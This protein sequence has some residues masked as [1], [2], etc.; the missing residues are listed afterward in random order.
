MSQHSLAIFFC[1]WIIARDS[2]KSVDSLVLSFLAFLLV[3]TGGRRR[4]SEKIETSRERDVAMA[5]RRLA[6]L[7]VD[8]EFFPFALFE[9]TRIKEIHS[10]VCEKI[11]RSSIYTKQ[12]VRNWANLLAA[13]GLLLPA[14][15][16]WTIFSNVW[17]VV[18]TSCVPVLIEAESRCPR[19]RPTR[20]SAVL[21]SSCHY[22]DV[23]DDPY[24]DHQSF[25]VAVL[26]FCLDARFFWP[27]PTH[28]TRLYPTLIITFG[29]IQFI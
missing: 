27:P 2:W 6:W 8:D 10:T 5:T 26:F 12:I 18:Y 15:S 1:L 25:E 4:R 7:N 21:I 3:A 28:P 14:C 13:I 24:L 16:Y 23:D 17:D 11:I 9:K 19:R 29:H 20:L 22:L